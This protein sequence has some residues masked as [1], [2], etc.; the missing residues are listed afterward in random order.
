MKSPTRSV[1]AFGVICIILLVG[2]ALAQGG[3]VSKEKTVD[4]KPNAASGQKTGGSG[5]QAASPAKAKHEVTVESAEIGSVDRDQT[6]LPKLTR[7]SYPKALSEEL[8]ADYQ[9]RLVMRFILKDVSSGEVLE[10]HQV[11]VQLVNQ[12]TKQEV[13]FVAE[14]D[15]AKQYKFDLNLQTKAK[16]FG[17]ESGVY[18]ISLIVGDASITNPLIW[19]IGKV[20]FTFSQAAAGERRIRENP[21]APRPEIR[22]LFRQPEK[23]PP[24]VISDAFSIL[25][26]LPLLLLFVLWIKLGVNISDFPLSLSAILFH[27][28]LALI[29]TLYGLFWLKMNMFT[30][31][32]CLSGVVLVAFLSGHRL[33]AWKASIKK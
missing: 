9:Q 28:S 22:H 29:F 20:K 8:E 24:Q 33:L 15:S 31:M 16:D 21:F 25:V 11:F 23:R 27:G 14:P 32:K 19:S 26:L 2:Q 17:H 5:A 1:G 12:D 3:T 4:S 6:T 30:T 13:I 10:P 7:L 18:S